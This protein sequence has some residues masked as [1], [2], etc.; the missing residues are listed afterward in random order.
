[1]NALIEQWGARNVGIAMLVLALLVLIAAVTIGWEAV[2][3]GLGIMAIDRAQAAGL[4]DDRL[5]TVANGREAA[6]WLPAE[7][8]AGILAIDLSDPAAKDQLARLE[9][10]VPAKQRPT[11][12]AINALHQVHHGGTPAGSLSSG[13]QAVI[14]HLVKLKQGEKPKELSLP[15]AD[16]PQVA[17]LTYAA[18][19]RF[20]AA[21]IQGDR[22]TIRVTAG[23]LRLLMPKHPDV[24]GVEVVLLALSP[25]VSNEVLRS[26]INVL[27]RGAR[28]DLL[29]Y[30]VMELAPERAAIIKPLLPAT[31]AGK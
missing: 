7:P 10:R 11:I 6:S 27:P 14:N 5:A 21:W 15:D 26:Q 4:I 28:R 20:R 19:A 17:L 1:M 25:S 3:R 18:Q 22:E 9:L 2:K 12:A 31:G 23:E 13:D 8:A 24:P 29:L 30:K 16:P